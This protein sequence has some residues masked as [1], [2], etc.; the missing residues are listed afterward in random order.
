[1]P[2][3][4][5][6]LLRSVVAVAVAVGAMALTAGTSSASVAVPWHPAA[7]AAGMA[8]QPG[9]LRA[10]P[11]SVSAKAEKNT[12]P[13][14]IVFGKRPAGPT[15]QDTSTTCFVDGAAP[16]NPDPQNPQT[17]STDIELDCTGAIARATISLWLL[18]S[19][20]G[21]NFSTLANNLN[22]HAAGTPFIV[23]ATGFQSVCISQFYVGFADVDVVFLSGSPIEEEAQFETDTIS[24]PC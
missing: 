15:P 21:V 23:G 22:N 18:D 2:K 4:I 11:A 13:L 10:L 20:D 14:H 5:N 19:L 9:V 24:L 7:P 8:V 17:I 3:R 16:F 12:R 1:M 6:L